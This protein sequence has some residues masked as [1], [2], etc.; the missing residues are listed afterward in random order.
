MEISEAKELSKVRSKLII[1]YINDIL[2]N[3]ENFPSNYY[4][5]FEISSISLIIARR[6][7][8]KSLIFATASS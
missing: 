3:T 1:E 5:D 7:Y 2:Y 8:D 4:D 6:L